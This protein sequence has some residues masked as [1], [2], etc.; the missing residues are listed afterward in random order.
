[1]S[2]LPL[3]AV[4][5][6]LGAACTDRA[7]SPD[8]DRSTAASYRSYVRQIEIVAQQYRDAML[9]AS[10]PTCPGIFG[11]YNR[12][13]RIALG[14][15]DALAPEVDLVITDHG[16]GAFADIGC[17]T[18][19]LRVEL[20]A[21]TAVAC[22]ATAIDDDRAETTRHLTA[23]DA[24]TAQATGRIEEILAGVDAGSATYLWTLPLACP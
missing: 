15:L 1:V 22:T 23:F 10:D 2:S 12:E 13:A 19:A 4:G 3:L 17:V 18:A 6:V 5:V 8:P 21:H 20:D 24:I 16:G 11:R 14:W 9:N 7:D